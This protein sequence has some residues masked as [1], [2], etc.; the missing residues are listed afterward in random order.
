M[1]DLRID[2][3]DTVLLDVPLR[4]PHRFAR[5]GMDTQPVLL[6]HIRTRGGVIGTGEGVVPG[7]PWWGG[8]S[9]ETMRLIIEGYLAPLL[10]GRT[11]DD[12]AGIQRDLGD[13]VA[14]NLYA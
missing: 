1:N 10:L 4:R 5:A 14:A 3:V 7:G 2:R 6:V 8:E 13:V 12:I 11:V 9:V